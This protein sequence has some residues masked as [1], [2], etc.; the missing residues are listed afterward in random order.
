VEGWDWH[1]G[2][3]NFSK[4]PADGGE[5]QMV[6]FPSVILSL[7]KDQFRFGLA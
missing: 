4:A 7:L 1:V 2:H 3:P 6:N 5:I